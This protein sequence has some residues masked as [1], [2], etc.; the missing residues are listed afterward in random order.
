MTDIAVEQTE[1]IGRKAGR[2]LGW[3]LL[4][5]A[6][7]KVGSFAT[8]LVLARLLVPNDFGV[9]AVALAATQLV[10]HIN[11]VGLIPAT[12]HWRGRLEEMAA[13]ATTIAGG[14]SLLVYL[15]FWFAAPSFAHLSG[16]PEATPVI[17]LFTATILV[18]GFTAV[19]SAYL[20]RTFQ[21]NKYVQANLAGIVANAAVAITM[22]LA[23]AGPMSLAGG[24]LASSLATGVLVFFWA[25]LPLR[26]GI[27]VRVARKLLAYGIPLTVSLGVESVLEQA[28][29]VIIGRA[30]GATVLGFYLLAFSISS[31][32]PGLIGS[33]V[34]YVSLP[35]FARLSEENDAAL[36]RGVQR[37]VPLLVIGLIPI[38]V[39]IAVLAEPTISFLYGTKWLAAAQPLR[40]LMILMVVRM[41]Y[42]IGMDILMSTGATRSTLLVNLGWATAVIPALWLGTR[43]DGGRG[44]AIAQAVVGLLVALPLIVVA[45]R[46]SGVDL[47]PIAP[48]LVRPLLG[49]AL[50]ATVALLLHLVVGSNPF[51]QLTTAGTAGLLVYLATAVPRSDLRGWVLAIRRK[52]AHAVSK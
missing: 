37:T 23:G 8:A 29:K 21:Q 33:A 19:R 41:L 28:D 43:F 52:E 12:I 47:A 32:A 46:R 10:L 22:S 3:G 7:T 13:T 35:G 2:G 31:W 11:D 44:A 30:M 1:S 14:F 51:V 18:D 48:L 34:R 36:S 50:A 17:R 9:Y 26:V 20:L 40:F 49:G 24:Q 42:G 5:N 4:G 27:D 45:L 38:A 6:A 25:R 15:G 16:V 39:L